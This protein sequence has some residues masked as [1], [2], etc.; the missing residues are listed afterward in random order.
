M[1]NRCILEWEKNTGQK[2]PRYSEPVCG[3]N[4]AILRKAGDLYDAHHI[5][6]NKYGGDHA[7]WNITPARFFDEHQAGIHAANGPASRLFK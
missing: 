4:G 2:W 5:I 1:K 3:K 6:E 7:W